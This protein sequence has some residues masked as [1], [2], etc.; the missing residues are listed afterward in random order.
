LLSGPE[1]SGPLTTQESL[2]VS[3]VL[4]SQEAAT[5][6]RALPLTLADVYRQHAADVGRW[7]ARLGGPRLDVDDIVQEVFLVVHRQLPGFRHEAKLGTWLF[8]ITDRVVR[9]HRR[10]LAVRRLVTTLT[11][12]QSEELP[13]GDADAHE[14]LERHASARAAYRVLDRLPDRY[15][16][17]LILAELEEL[18]AEEIARLLEARIETVRVWLHRAR[19]MLAEQIR[20]GDGAGDGDG[21]TP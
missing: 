10:W 11:F 12:R 20:D 3:V 16:R 5:T 13:S 4:S 1:I 18:P 17:V 9:N 14:T 6:P 2:S 21:G 15:R 8:R 19:R 7:A